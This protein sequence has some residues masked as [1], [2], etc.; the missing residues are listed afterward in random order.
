MA[1]KIDVFE[2][3]FLGMEGKIKKTLGETEE[4]GH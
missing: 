4:H 1:Q 3:P 2:N